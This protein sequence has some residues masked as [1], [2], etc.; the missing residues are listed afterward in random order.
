[1]QIEE[2]S[3]LNL[4][5]KFNQLYVCNGGIPFLFINASKAKHFLILIL[6]VFFL[7]KTKIRISNLNKRLFRLTQNPQKLYPYF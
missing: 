3:A 5:S 2:K 4:T 6:F 7:C 1:M